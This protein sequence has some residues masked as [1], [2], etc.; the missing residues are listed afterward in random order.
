MARSAHRRSGDRRRYRA[1]PAAIRGGLMA[2]S[3]LAAKADPEG[4]RGEHRGG[5]LVVN[6]R[7]QCVAR[8]APGTGAV[9]WWPEPITPAT[10][11]GARGDPQWDGLGGGGSW[12]CPCQPLDAL[13]R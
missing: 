6:A 7:V 10:V 3:P 5:G 8:S 4:I 12:A 1:R 13:S 2:S 11:P 9:T